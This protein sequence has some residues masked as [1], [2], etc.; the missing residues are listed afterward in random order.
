MEVVSWEVPDFF[1]HFPSVLIAVNTSYSLAP[2]KTSLNKA[3]IR[4]VA[5]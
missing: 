2:E 4:Y 1:Q 3:V 5:F